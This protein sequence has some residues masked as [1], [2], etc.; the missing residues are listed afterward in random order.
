MRQR[1]QITGGADGALA[2]NTWP[3]LRVV[4]RNQRLQHLPTHAGVAACERRDLQREDQSDACVV[5]QFTDTGC[6]R[7]HQIGLQLLELIG[8][9]LH[10]GE[11][12]ETGVDPVGGLSDGDDIPDG[13]RR[14]AYL[15]FRSEEHTSELPSLM[16]LSYAVF[17]LKK[18]QKKHSQTH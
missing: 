18:K 1:R 12:S 8:W 2:G 10:L 5:Q 17:C 3:D 6:M 7:S 13:G 9:D 16:R 11:L 15:R 4:H 14:G